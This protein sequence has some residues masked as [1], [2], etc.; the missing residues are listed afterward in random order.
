MAL[1]GKDSDYQT[2]CYFKTYFL[3]I[4][5]QNFKDTEKNFTTSQSKTEKNQ[6]ICQG[7]EK[8]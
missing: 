2:E 4:I 8:H 7:R 1:N 5:W 6:V 3:D